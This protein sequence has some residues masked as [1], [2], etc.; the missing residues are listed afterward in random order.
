MIGQSE[1][2]ETIIIP[3]SGIGEIPNSRKLILQNKLTNKLKQFFRIV[4]QEKYEQVLEQVFEELEYEECSEDTCIMRVQEML[5]VE[6]VFHLQLIGEGNDIQLNLKWT[7]LEEKR[8]EEYF[9]EKCSTK[10]LY[11]KLEGLVEKLVGVKEIKPVV[12]VEKK[13]KGVLYKRFVDGN[14]GWFENGDVTKDYIYE[15]EIENGEPNGHGLL[16]HSDGDRYVGGWKDGR[17]NGQGTITYPDGSKYVGESKN[18]LFWNTTYYDTNRNIKAKWVNG[19]KEIEPVVFRTEPVPEPEPKPDP[20]THLFKMRKVYFPYQKNAMESVTFITPEGQDV[21]QKNYQ[22][23]AAN[24]DVQI[25]LEG[26]SY[27]GATNESNLIL[28][29][30][31]AKAVFDYLIFLGSSPSQFSLV[32]FG[33]ERPGVCKS[34]FI[35]L[36]NK[37]EI[38]RDPTIDTT[39]NNFHCVEF[40][41]L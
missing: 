11:Y 17:H 1:R 39:K 26:H 23:I 27:Q 22:W 16:T 18:G 38:Y 14:W 13:Q 12:M 29:E 6:N 15:G 5:Q 32:S 24:P 37:G 10:D 19:V 3:V 30:L 21:I 40:T 28:G 4:P 25:Q 31:V 41:Q 35:K 9:C 8:N 7:T 33:Q 34:N 2:P 20:E 36:T